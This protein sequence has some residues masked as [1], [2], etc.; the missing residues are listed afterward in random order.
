M[1]GG[2][3]GLGVASLKARGVFGTTDSEEFKGRRLIFLLSMN[4]RYDQKK[5]KTSEIEAVVI[6]AERI[7]LVYVLRSICIIKRKMFFAAITFLLIW[8]NRREHH[9]IAQILGYQ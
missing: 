7:L 6:S 2:S 4:R 3:S 9:H 1:R 5:E 8:Y